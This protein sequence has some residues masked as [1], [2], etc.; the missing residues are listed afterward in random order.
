[1]SLVRGLVFDKVEN[2]SDVCHIVQQ[3]VDKF[4]NLKIDFLQHHYQSLTQMDEYKQEKF[5]NFVHYIDVKFSPYGCRCFFR[6]K[7]FTILSAATYYHEFYDQISDYTNA[8]LS[9]LAKYSFMDSIECYSENLMKFPQSILSL[10]ESKT[11]EFH[12]RDDLLFWYDWSLNNENKN[13]LEER[14]RNTEVNNLLL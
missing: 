8:E 1:M 9:I 13:A 6:Q 7:L 14:L 5:L 11:S 10:I 12:K 3:N 4:L 2:V